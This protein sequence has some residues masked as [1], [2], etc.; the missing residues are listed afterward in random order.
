[1]NE[2]KCDSQLGGRGGGW[3]IAL[4]RPSDGSVLF[5]NKWA[6]ETATMTSVGRCRSSHPIYFQTGIGVLVWYMDN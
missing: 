2:K 3:R 6:R 1:M 5:V 4:T